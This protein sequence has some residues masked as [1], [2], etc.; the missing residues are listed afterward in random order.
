MKT[1][2]NIYFGIFD[3][4]LS[5]SCTGLIILQTKAV[6]IM[7]FKEQ[8]FHLNTKI[9]LKLR[10]QITLQNI[11]P[12]SSSINKQVPLGLDYIFRKST[13]MRDFLVCN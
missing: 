10:D 6:Q 11:L 8:L 7:N 1:L 5:C 2:R 3:P 12:V 13:L 4:H 9:I